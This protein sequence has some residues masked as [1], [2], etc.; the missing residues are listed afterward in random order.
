MDNWCLVHKKNFGLIRQVV[1][2]LGILYKIEIGGI[3]L[4]CLNGL[5]EKSQATIAVGKFVNKP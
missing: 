1:Y 3:L 4:L 5:G 2:K